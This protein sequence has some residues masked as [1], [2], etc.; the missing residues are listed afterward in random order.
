D[1]RR[2]PR[3]AGPRLRQEPRAAHDVVDARRALPP[4]GAL[5]AQL[6]AARD[7]AEGLVRARREEQRAAA[8]GFLA[9]AS[10]LRLTSSHTENPAPAG[11]FFARRG[12]DLIV[13]R[14]WRS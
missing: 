9:Q 10:L 2:A 12:T 5:D 14:F 13:P 4:L 1:R 11:F 7:P 3:R 6:R 8:G